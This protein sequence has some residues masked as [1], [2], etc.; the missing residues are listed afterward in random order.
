MTQVTQPPGGG[1]EGYSPCKAT[2]LPTSCHLRPGPQWLPLSS[3][4]GGG[5]PGEACRVPWATGLSRPSWWALLS[6]PSRRT[7]G[8]VSAPSPPLSQSTRT[9]RSR[10]PPGCV[11]AQRQALGRSTKGSLCAP[12]PPP[13]LFPPTEGSSRVAASA[14]RGCR[15]RARGQAGRE[16]ESC[17]VAFPCNVSPA[18]WGSEGPGPPRGR[19][20]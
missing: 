1:R 7:G 9:A 2:L 15:G 12:R 6:A 19:S 3:P 20:D 14:P 11:R 13:W 8:P 4:E 10:A 18:G 17:G 16:N 5:G